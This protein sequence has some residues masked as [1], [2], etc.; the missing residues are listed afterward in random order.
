MN[1]W[2]VFLLSPRIAAVTVINCPDIW[3]THKVIWF[4]RKHCNLKDFFLLKEIWRAFEMKS[5]FQKSYQFWRRCRRIYFSH[6][7]LDR[8]IWASKLIK[9]SISYTLIIKIKMFFISVA[10]ISSRKSHKMRRYIVNVT[11]FSL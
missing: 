11:L 2:L 7:I 1:Q 4:S 8:R 10:M 6:I 3:N 9:D 5:L